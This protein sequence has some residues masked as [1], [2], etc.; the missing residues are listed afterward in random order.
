MSESMTFRELFDHMEIYV[1][2]KDQRFK[3][4]MRTKRALEHPVEKGGIGNDQCYFQGA[5]EILR[6]LENVNLTTMYS[7]KVCY[8]EINRIKRLA[9]MDCIKIPKFAQDAERYKRSLRE[10]GYLNNLIERPPKKQ[11]EPPR[12]AKYIVSQTPQPSAVL[13]SPQP[14]PTPPPI[15]KKMISRQMPPINRNS[16][17]LSRSPFSPV[18]YNDIQ[19]E[20][21]FER[22]KQSLINNN[23]SV[24]SEESSESD[25]DDNRNSTGSHKILRHR[26]KSLP[27]KIK[28]PKRHKRNTKTPKSDDT[29]RALGNRRKSRH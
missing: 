16:G 13:A 12:Q 3:H 19:R 11:R 14:P 28:K 21:S 8:D 4:V 2:N 27:N 24:Q 29:G 5:V 18:I 22:S 7:G 23:S 17:N 1:P 6:N 10:I 9:R 26:P 15:K 25:D 20:P